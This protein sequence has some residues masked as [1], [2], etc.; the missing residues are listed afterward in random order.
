MPYGN[1]W[2]I[3]LPFHVAKEEF[4]SNWCFVIKG[5]LGTGTKVVENR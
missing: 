4:N 2:I 5:E 3:L 1:E